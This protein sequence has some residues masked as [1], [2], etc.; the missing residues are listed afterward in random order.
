MTAAALSAPSNSRLRI[1]LVGCGWFACEAHLPALRRL[2]RDGKI[3]LVALCSR[4]EASLSRATKAYGPKHLKKYINIADLLADPEIDLV[5]LVLPIPAMPEAI[6]AALRA[7]KHVI[8]EKPCAPTVAASVELLNYH[9]SLAAPT[10]WAVAEN[11][12]FKKS[13]S[14]IER[15]VRS[16]LIGAI[17]FADFRHMT[18]TG[19]EGLGWRGTPAYPG[20]ALLD[21]GVHFVGLLRKLVGEVASVSATV[22]QRLKYLSPADSVTAVIRFAGGAEGSF[23]LSFATEKPGDRPGLSLVGSHGAIFANFVSNQIEIHS[24]SQK[25]IIHVKNDSWVEGGVYELLAHCVD[26]VRPDTPLRST[27][28]EALRDVA[29]IEAMLESNL[30]AKYVAPSSLY[31]VLR[32]RGRRIDTYG[33]VWTFEPRHVVECSSVQEV[34]SVVAD[35]A[36]AGLRVR[37]MGNNNSWAPHLL[38]DGLC[39]SLRGLDRIRSLDVV[40]KTVVVEAGARLGD[41]TRVL[42]AKNLS[43]P[44]LS[45]LSDAS[46]GGAIATGTHGTSSKWGTLSDFVR[47]MT[48]VL[49]SGAVQTFDVDSAPE[50]FRAARVAI[51]MLGIIVEVE[52]QAIDMPWVRFSEIPMDLGTF[53]VECPSLLAKYEHVW[54]HW[55]LGRDGVLAKCLERRAQPAKGFHR[56]IA[57]DNALWENSTLLDQGIRDAKNALRPLKKLLRPTSQAT[58]A[59]SYISATQV[60]MSTQYGVPASAFERTIEMMRVSDFSKANPGRVVEIKFLK[61]SSQSYLGPNADRDSALFNLWWLIDKSVQHS[62]F[63]SFETLMRSVCARPHWGKYHRPPDAAYL[64]GAYS[65]WDEFEKVRAK[66]DP[67]KTFAIY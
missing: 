23:R 10:L 13:T 54:V 62:A 6:R 11:W 12:R 56:Y 8:S 22:S 53:L 45:F 37:A 15:I 67:G 50:E 60:W 19:P 30:S 46:I 32:G 35:A 34:S 31:P 4:S 44:S 27:P 63:E 64:K 28:W 39:V 29:V 26:A 16:G 51:G 33:G 5:D 40:N 59:E 41:I 1:A 25:K 7:G 9:D 61:G 47:S 2:E 66:F 43:L 42:A 36:S 24:S 3:E 55:T 21:S 52:L 49:A 48:L 14:I 57:G 18:L 20:G 38:T 58:S 17:Q 65:N